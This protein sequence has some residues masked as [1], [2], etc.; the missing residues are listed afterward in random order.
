[1]K[2]L[3]LISII[4]FSGLFVKAQMLTPFDTTIVGVHY[5]FYVTSQNQSFLGDST[6]YYTGTCAYRVGKKNYTDPF[7]GSIRGQDIGLSVNT[8]TCNVAYTNKLLKRKFKEAAILFLN[9]TEAKN[10]V[11]H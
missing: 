4:V 3:I 11:N 10:A 1:M 6:Y 5:H 8:N 7:C 9:E 2:K